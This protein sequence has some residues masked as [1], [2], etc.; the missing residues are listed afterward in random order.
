MAAYDD[1]L[2]SLLDVHAP[3]RAVR[4]S[5][6]PSQD[7]FDADCRAAN[8]LE[9]VYRRHSNA[10]TQLAGKITTSRIQGL[11]SAG[12]RR[13][14]DPPHPSWDPALLFVDPT[15]T[16]GDLLEFCSVMSLLVIVHHDSFKYAFKIFPCQHVAVVDFT[17]IERC[18][19]DHKHADVCLYSRTIVISFCDSRFFF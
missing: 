3:Y 2:A 15:P 16:F 9:R 11:N 19:D 10:E 7:W 6:R 17:V 5:T 4:R 13:I 1:T 8:S 14:P 12:S 18:G